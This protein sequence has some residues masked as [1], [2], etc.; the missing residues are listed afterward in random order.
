[1]FELITSRTP[2]TGDNHIQL[3]KNIESKAPRFPTHVSQACNALLFALL[4][5]DP[6]QRLC[7]ESFFNHE[8]LARA[9]LRPPEESVT[10][11][12]P[13]G[14][15][16][17]ARDDPQAGISSRGATPSTATPSGHLAH[18]PHET[19]AA[20][21]ESP[22]AGAPTACQSATPV[23]Q[24]A[25][26]AMPSQP[27]TPRGRMPK[28]PGRTTCSRAA[29]GSTERS[30]G[31]LPTADA[32]DACI[33]SAATVDACSSS[34]RYSS[35][36][37]SRCINCSCSCS[38]QQCI[39]KRS[40]Q[41]HTTIISIRL[42]RTSSRCNYP[43]SLCP[44]LAFPRRDACDACERRACVRCSTIRP[45]APPARVWPQLAPAAAEQQQQLGFAPSQ[46]AASPMASPS[47][48][49]AIAPSTIVRPSPTRST[50][51][52]APRCSCGANG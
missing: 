31:C 4:Q 9:P 16:P 30:A 47:A 51:A 27:E 7:F 49:A 17:P 8:F 3:L 40:T 23:A 29:Y 26:V 6:M 48:A 24:P 36:R 25:P 33:G 21:G 46:S 22:S 34:S 41:Q 42:R 10:P 35:S 20:F 2:Y 39:T 45:A 14:T 32:A 38:K 19:G 52:A 37:Y 44:T 18:I 43:V 15:T 28:L 12:A 11:P 5:R 1:M 50:A 13:N